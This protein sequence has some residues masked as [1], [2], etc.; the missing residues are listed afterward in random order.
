MNMVIERWE[1][2]VSDEGEMKEDI[3]EVT[4]L[5]YVTSNVS[6]MASNGTR[7][8][9]AYKSTPPYKSQ[10][11]GTS[12]PTRSFTS[13]ISHLTPPRPHHATSH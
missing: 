13:R 1:Y 3:Y 4:K 6:S 8:S 10:C 2:G 11:K 7:M 12:H 5:Q 9:G